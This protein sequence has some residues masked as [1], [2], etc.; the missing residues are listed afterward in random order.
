MQ[1]DSI[2]AVLSEPGALGVVRFRGE[3]QLCSALLDRDPMTTTNARHS[4]AL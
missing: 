1:T 2:F 3:N 4:F